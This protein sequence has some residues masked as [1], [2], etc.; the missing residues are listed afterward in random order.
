HT[1]THTHTH[2][3]THAHTHTHPHPHPRTRTHTHAHTNPFAGERLGVSVFS[4]CGWKRVYPP[5]RKNER[6]RERKRERETER[7]GRR[8]RRQT[9]FC[10]THN[11][12]CATPGECSTNNNN[13]DNGDI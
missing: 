5:L 13:G 6:E 3:H 11:E 4:V 9:I 2:A 7:D 10:G 12:P 1:Q 8:E